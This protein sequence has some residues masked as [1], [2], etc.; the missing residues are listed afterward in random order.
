MHE[1]FYI[2]IYIYI[3][4]LK[5][6]TINKSCTMKQTKIDNKKKVDFAI[7]PTFFHQPNR[8]IKLRKNIYS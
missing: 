4:I 8:K 2:I 3:I 1:L 6:F 7:I 5:Y